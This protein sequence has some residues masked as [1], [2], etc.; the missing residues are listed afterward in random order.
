M[1]HYMCSNHSIVYSTETLIVFHT[2]SSC[3][4]VSSQV[5]QWSDCR[6]MTRWWI[7]GKMWLSHVRWPQVS[8]HPPWYGHD[9]Q[10]PFPSALRSVGPLWPSGPSLHLMQDSTT[11]QLSTMWAT[12]L[13]RSPTSLSGVSVVYVAIYLS[14]ALLYTSVAERRITTFTPAFFFS[15]RLEEWF[16]SSTTSLSVPVNHKIKC[17]DVCREVNQS[18]ICFVW[19]NLID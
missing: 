10:V 11:A 5:P 14:N 4:F 12:P 3:L 7:L 1:F 6:S 16:T 15:E 9:T 13:A 8:P 18:Q 2:I 17:S 19:W